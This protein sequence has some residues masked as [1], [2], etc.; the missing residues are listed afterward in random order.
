MR[1]AVAGVIREEVRHL[2]PLPAYVLNRGSKP[3]HQA[4]EFFTKFHKFPRGVGPVSEDAK[5]SLR[6]HFNAMDW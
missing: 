4:P 2:I 3:V 5:E 6:V 1:A